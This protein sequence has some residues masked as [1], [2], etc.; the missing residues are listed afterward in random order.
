M[1]QRDHYDA[2]ASLISS[3]FCLVKLL[4]YTDVRD[5]DLFLCGSSFHCIYFAL[6]FLLLQGIGRLEW[7]IFRAYSDIFI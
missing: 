4:L 7:G 2:L 5:S 6:C 1:S 3:L